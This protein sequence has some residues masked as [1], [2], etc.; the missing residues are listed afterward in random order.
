[1]HE[2]QHTVHAGLVTDLVHGASQWSVFRCAL[3]IHCIGCMG[4]LNWIVFF[5]CHHCLVYLT[6]DSHLRRLGINELVN[7]SGVLYFF[8]IFDHP[9]LIQGMIEAR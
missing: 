4:S 5:Y 6:G 9:E 2:S 7:A 8:Y 1:M 3:R